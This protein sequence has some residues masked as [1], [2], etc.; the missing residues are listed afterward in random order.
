MHHILIQNDIEIFD[1]R[2]YVRKY[3]FIKEVRNK[4]AA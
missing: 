2:T 1:L 3:Y 4:E